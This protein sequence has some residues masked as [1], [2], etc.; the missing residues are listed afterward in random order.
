MENAK[1]I[2]DKKF[3]WD[4]ETYP[5]KEKAQEVISNYEK[6]R[7][8]TRLIKEGDEYFVFSRRIVTEIVIEGQQPS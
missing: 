1:I 7:F 8:E 5:G 4:G 2:D 3:M 6:E